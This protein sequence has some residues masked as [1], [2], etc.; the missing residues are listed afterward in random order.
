MEIDK[1]KLEKV[2]HSCAI[3]AQAVYDTLK[4]AERAAMD[5]ILN[6]PDQIA[7]ASIVR[8][9]R[10]AGCSEAT[11]VRLARR[12]GYDG[13]P[14][15]KTAFQQAERSEE[16]VV[17]KGITAHDDP[18]AVVEKV[19][20][21]S[22]QSLHDTLQVIDREQYRR[23][24]AAIVGARRLLFC[25]LGDAAL[26]AASVCQ[27]FLRVN[28]DAQ[29]SEDPDMQL[30]MAS[31][32]GARDVLVAV[33]HSGR[34]TTIIHTIDEARARGAT[35]VA[36]TNYPLSPL[37]KASDIVLLTADFAEHLNG[38]VVSKRVSEQCVLESLYIN[39]LIARNG[40]LLAAQERANRAV[41]VYKA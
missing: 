40:E 30:I 14:G 11:L 7:E 36:V 13:F 29:S 1:G 20:A 38:E 26:V 4:R 3:K 35:T 15:L 5:Y 22:I 23:A 6:H 32:L 19:F 24:V 9:A 18:L 39:Y 10:E 12:L 2:P 21:A 37:A 33:S 16:G 27:K 34:S 8:V 31:H 41:E 28:A 17:Y 25:G